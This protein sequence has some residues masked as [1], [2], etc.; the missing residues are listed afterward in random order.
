MYILHLQ[1]AHHFTFY[2]QDTSSCSSFTEEEI[3]TY[4]EKVPFNPYFKVQ[5]NKFLCPSKISSLT[6]VELIFSD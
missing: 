5:Y 2:F 1:F 3:N 4:F 6:L